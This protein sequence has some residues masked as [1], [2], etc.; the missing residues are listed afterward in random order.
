[1]IIMES[2]LLKNELKRM[3]IMAES[4]INREKCEEFIKKIRKRLL[5]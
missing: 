2:T 3:E 4:A 5:F 1:M